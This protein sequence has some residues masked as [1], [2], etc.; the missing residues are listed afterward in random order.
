[1]FNPRTVI[2]PPARIPR[3]T[4]AS[5][6]TDAKSQPFRMLIQGVE[7]SGKSSLAAG[8]PGAVF[9]CPEDGLPPELAHTPHFPAPD[10][11][12]WTAADVIDAVRSLASG[13]HDYKTLVLDTADWIEP[14]IWADL[15]AREK[16]KD[17]EVP[18]YGKGYAAALSDWR[19]L[20]AELEQLRKARGMNILILAHSWIRPFKDPESDGWDRYELKL[21]KGAAGLLKE[22]VDAVLFLKHDVVAVKDGA[23]S[24]R[25]RGVATGDRVL[26]T[27]Y[28]GAFDAG[29]RY[30]LPDQIIIPA[31]GG[32]EVLASEMRI[33]PGRRVAE[34]RAGIEARLASLG[35]QDSDKAK[36]MLER[37]GADASMLAQLDNWCA[38]RAAKKGS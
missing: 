16:W 32:W 35:A 5:I 21:H 37:A 36:G 9:I 17:I 23:K 20:V 10:E 25:T 2:F 4:L 13:E 3:L 38:E 22:W 14:L 6:T 27:S 18:G 15:C 24:A 34:L 28:S 31:V 29:N 1:M 33:G 26:H 8:A 11:G 30:N 19:R 12:E 7:K